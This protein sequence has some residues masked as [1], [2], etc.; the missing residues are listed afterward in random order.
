MYGKALTRLFFC[1]IFMLSLGTGFV[2]AGADKAAN[3]AKDAYNYSRK[4]YRA[5]TLGYL[6]Y[7]ANKAME[8]AEK[9]KL[10]AD[11]VGADEA[12]RYA[13]DA[14]DYARKAKETNNLREARHFSKEAMSAAQAAQSA[15]EK[16]EPSAKE[17][18]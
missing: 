6:K 11:D 2:F 13:N 7:Q 16:Y 10:E 4:A 9:A 18:K 12:A 15:A 5:N 8:A 1:F 14:S 17:A 3:Y